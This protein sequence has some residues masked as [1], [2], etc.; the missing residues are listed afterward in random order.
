ML[1][2][3]VVRRTD[4]SS[5]GAGGRASAMSRFWTDLTTLAGDYGIL[6]SVSVSRSGLPCPYCQQMP[7]HPVGTSQ[8]L[9]NPWGAAMSSEPLGDCLAFA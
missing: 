1:C 6:A 2:C 8:K 4:S 5:K 9:Y 7:V 3:S